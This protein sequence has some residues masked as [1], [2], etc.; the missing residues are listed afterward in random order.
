MH[1]GL[2][3]VS[4]WGLCG[5]LALIHPVISHSQKMPPIPVPGSLGV[6][7]G[8]EWSLQDAG[9]EDDPVLGGQVVGVHGLWGHAPPGAG[10]W[11]RGQA[12]MCPLS[13]L[14]WHPPVLCPTAGPLCCPAQGWNCCPHPMTKEPSSGDQPELPQVTYN[15]V[16]SH[17]GGPSS[18]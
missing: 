10:R 14:P 15:T 17:G 7:A 2:C 4:V 11:D 8:I 5:V 9:R 18:Q 3:F 16:L 13:P 1:S 6:V 12:G